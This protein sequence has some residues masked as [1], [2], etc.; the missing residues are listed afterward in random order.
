MKQVNTID[1]PA[2]WPGTQEEMFA[3]RRTHWFDP[4]FERCMDCDCRPWGRIAEWPCGTQV[5]RV[6]YLVT[7]TLREEGK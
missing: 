5:P 6:T 3:N 2:P 1:A 7:N 4:E